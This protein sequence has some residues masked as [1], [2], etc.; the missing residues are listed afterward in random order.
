MTTVTTPIR[1]VNTCHGRIEMT[2]ERILGIAREY[3]DSPL[4]DG[5]ICNRELKRYILLN[6]TRFIKFR[7]FKR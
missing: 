2:I 5:Y 6:S 1:D 3:L 7:R 4:H